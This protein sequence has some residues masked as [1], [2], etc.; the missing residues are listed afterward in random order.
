M[1]SDMRRCLKYF[2]SAVDLWTIGP[3]LL[4]SA[5]L[6]APPVNA[7]TPSRYG[8]MPAN[9]EGIYEGVGDF[10]SQA[11]IFADDRR[12][13]KFV[14]SRASQL[15]GLKPL[16]PDLGALATAHLQPWALAEMKSP[17]PYATIDDVGAMCGPTGNFR[18]ASTGSPYMLLQAPGVILL[19]SLDLDQV[20]IERIYLTD[21]H[22]DNI[23]PTW[24]GDSIGHWEG[25]TLVVDTIGYNDKSW[26]FSELQPH[27]E[28]LHVVRRLRLRQD[29]RLLEIYS[30][31]DDRQALRA[32]FSFSRYYL[33]T[34]VTFE[35][36]T[37][38]CND[39]VGAQADWV[40]LRQE[41]M[42]DYQNGLKTAGKGIKEAGYGPD[43]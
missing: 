22:P 23:F 25:D 32:P 1:G 29:S 28:A 42:A 39:A 9:W 31:V 21:K 41:A 38:R 19:I 18:H 40:R 12:S 7:Q 14:L 2:H 10:D 36:K 30:T 20:G 43:H 4:L 24:D 13:D 6:V 17:Q 15:G 33:R 26:L 27:T 3:S 8:P 34:G 37:T 35:Q 16:N 11:F 5:L